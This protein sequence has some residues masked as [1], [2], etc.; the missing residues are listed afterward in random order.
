[1]NSE[2]RVHKSGMKWHGEQVTE[3]AATG[4]KAMPKVPSLHALGDPI[5]FFLSSDRVTLGWGPE[6]SKACPSV[7]MWTLKGLLGSDGFSETFEF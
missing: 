5:G 7:Y 4:D 2:T 3:S 1:M 6:D